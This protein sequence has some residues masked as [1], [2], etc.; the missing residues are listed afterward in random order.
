MGV[1]SE[2]ATGDLGRRLVIGRDRACGR[3]DAFNGGVEHRQKVWTDP[4]RAIHQRDDLAAETGS[5]RG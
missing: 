3:V 5:L 4:P 2:D 1:G